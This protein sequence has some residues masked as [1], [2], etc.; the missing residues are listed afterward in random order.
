MVRCNGDG[1]G[2]SAPLF[3]FFPPASADMNLLLPFPYEWSPMPPSLP[4]ALR[5]LVRSAGEHRRRGRAGPPTCGRISGYWVWNR[6]P[7][8]FSSPSFEPCGFF[9]PEVGRR[10]CGQSGAR[11]AGG[12][13][14]LLDLLVSRKGG[15][16]GAHWRRPIISVPRSV[17]GGGSAEI[18]PSSFVHDVRRRGEEREEGGRMYTWHETREDLF[19]A[20]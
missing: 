9:P 8:F 14:I 18:S 16:A 10:E 5:L 3:P 17:L 7:C 1:V 15:P 20:Y 19:L 12:M 2:L 4:V 11:L 6:V 13:R